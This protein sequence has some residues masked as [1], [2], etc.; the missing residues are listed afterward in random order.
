ML[1]QNIYDYHNLPY[2]IKKERTQFES[3]ASPSILKRRAF[4]NNDE[5]NVRRMFR[6]R[7]KMIL[8]GRIPRFWDV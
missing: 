7:K 6:E 1:L 3:K 2:C 8:K 4:P 5:I